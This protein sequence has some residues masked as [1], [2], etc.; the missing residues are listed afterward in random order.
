[1]VPNADTFIYS[2]EWLEQY[3]KMDYTIQRNED[4][5]LFV[6]WSANFSVN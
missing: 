3:R 1:M 5:R 4:I 2:W 6:Y